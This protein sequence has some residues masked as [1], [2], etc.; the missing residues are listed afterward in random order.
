MNEDQYIWTVCVSC[1][2]NS[3]GNFLLYAI[4]AN[5][6]TAPSDWLLHE[7]AAVED[8]VDAQLY[9]LSLIA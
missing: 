1:L 6:Y 9:L 2:E 3:T 4:R 8:P 5:K 7:W